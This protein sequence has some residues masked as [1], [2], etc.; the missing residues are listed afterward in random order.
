M[1]WNQLSVY[2]FSSNEN[3]IVVNECPGNWLT[4]ILNIHSGIYMYVF[5]TTGHISLKKYIFNFEI[6]RK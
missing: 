4:D 3:L 6:P 2:F 1:F 5:N